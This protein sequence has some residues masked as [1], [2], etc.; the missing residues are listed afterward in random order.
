MFADADL[1]QLV[2]SWLMPALRRLGAAWHAGAVSVAGEHFV[3]AGLQRRLAASLDTATA[4]PGAPRVLVGLSRGARHELGVLSYAV[5]LARTG[6]EVLYV[7]ADLP[8]DSWVV[9]VVAREPDAVVLGVPT[10]EDVPAVRDTVAALTAARPDLSVLL[11]GSHQDQIGA[12]IPLGHSLTDAVRDTAT[13]LGL[14]M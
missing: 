12:G 11:G 8:P 7:G 14:P 5:L 13:R 10:A 2:E 9:A 6:V 1:G 4:Q 3:S